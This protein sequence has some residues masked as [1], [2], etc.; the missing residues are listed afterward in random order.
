MAEYQYFPTFWGLRLGC[1]APFRPGLSFGTA[2]AISII[3]APAAP[4]R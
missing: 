2:L 4:L 3:L 1:E